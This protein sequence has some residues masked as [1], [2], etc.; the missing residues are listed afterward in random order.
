METKQEYYIGERDEQ[1]AFIKEFAV[2]ADTFDYKKFIRDLSSEMNAVKI[3][4][5]E[6]SPLLNDKGLPMA[7]TKKSNLKVVK[8]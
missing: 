2:N 4:V 7:D 1:I 8:E 3:D 5:P 6:V